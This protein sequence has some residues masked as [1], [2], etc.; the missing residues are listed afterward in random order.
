MG[1]TEEV[2]QILNNMAKPVGSLG[3]LEK[4]AKKTFL[5][6]GKI[7]KEFKPLHFIFAADNGVV[8]AGIVRQRSQITYMQS[9]HMLEGT[10]AIS[11]FCRINRIPY[12][13][14]DVGIDSEDAVGIDYKIAR[15]TKDFTQ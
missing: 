9:R 3:L 1:F 15:G 6:W 13:V 2:E 11:C 14:I 7:E 8:Q 12:R 5:A 4:H 10:A